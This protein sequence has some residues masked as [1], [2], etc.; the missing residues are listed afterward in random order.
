M[1]H[2][3]NTFL[4]PEIYP[5]TTTTNQSEH[6]TKRQLYYGDP[7]Y[8]EVILATDNTVVHFHGQ[9][10]LEQYI[11]TQISIVRK[12]SPFLQKNITLV[13]ESFEMVPN[14]WKC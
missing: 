12:F 5:N 2:Q 14:S 9:S 13:S 4:L 6:R 1:I 10:I 8:L 3:I 11:L 7:K